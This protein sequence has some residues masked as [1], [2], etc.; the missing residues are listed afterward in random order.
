MKISEEAAMKEVSL[1]RQA[2]QPLGTFSDAGACYEANVFW[3]WKE[4]ALTASEQKGSWLSEDK[5]A[6][7]ARKKKL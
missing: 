6:S 2:G 4:Q 1:L 7:E 5:K 3:Q